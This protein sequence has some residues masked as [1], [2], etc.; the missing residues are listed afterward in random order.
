MCFTSNSKQ[1]PLNHS[2]LNL[3]LFR[4]IWSHLTS[5]LCTNIPW[6]SSRFH[7]TVGP[8]CGI[9]MYCTYCALPW[10]PLSRD[11]KSHVRGFDS[12]QVHKDAT[13]VQHPRLYWS[14][15]KLWS[16]FDEKASYGVAQKP[17]LVVRTPKQLYYGVRMFSFSFL[18]FLRLWAELMINGRL[19]SS[20]CIRHVFIMHLLHR[21]LINNIYI[22]CIHLHVICILLIMYS[23]T[24]CVFIAC[25]LHIHVPF[26]A[27][28]CCIHVVFLFLSMHIADHVAVLSHNWLSVSFSLS[29]RSTKINTFCLLR[30]LVGSLSQKISYN[31]LYNMIVY[32]CVFQ[33]LLPGVVATW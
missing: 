29:C 27:Y 20:L 17:R 25:S 16:V 10:W 24:Q 28:S 33:V 4:L 5:N 8:A 32:R 14:D 23:V 22:Y 11:S 3:L 7:S 1:T 2:E 6:P 15:L 12:P 13:S 31:I 19:A 30:D 26:I 18:H 9:C 21:H